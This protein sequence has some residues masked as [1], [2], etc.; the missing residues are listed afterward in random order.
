MLAEFAYE[1][2][3]EPVPTRTGSDRLP[4]HPR[5]RPDRSP[6][7]G[8]PR[9]LRALAVHPDTVALEGR[10]SRPAALPRTRSPPCSPSTETLSATSS[11]NSPP[12][13]RPT[14]VSITPRSPS[15][16]SPTSTTRELEGHQT[17]HPWLVAQQGPYRLLS[18]RR[19]PLGARVPQQCTPALDR[20]PAPSSPVTAASQVSA[21]RI[22]STP[23]VGRFH[24]RVLR[25]RRC[26][27]AV[28]TR[29]TTCYL[30]VHPW[31]WDEVVVPLFAPA[32]AA[33]RD[34]SAPP[35][36]AI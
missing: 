25:R 3:I 16:T 14:P 29:R 13:S 19:R 22:G 11:A 10:S 1:E 5:P 27:L 21:H 34:R 33:Q 6:F 20:R 26:A 23:G 31:Q 32:I 15:P 9:G 18:D 8:P 12:R 7:P 17:G 24:P 28:W 35:P 4:A 36:T 30:P 2:I